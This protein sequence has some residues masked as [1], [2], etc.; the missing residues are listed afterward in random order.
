M[1]TRFATRAT[2]VDDTINV[3]ENLQKHFLCPRVVL[4]ATDGLHRQDTMLPPQCVLV[5]SRPK[6]LVV[7]IISLLTGSPQALR[8]VFWGKAARAEKLGRV[9][10]APLALLPTPHSRASFWFAPVPRARCYQNQAESLSGRLQSRD[11]YTTR[12]FRSQRSFNRVTFTCCFCSQHLVP[13]PVAITH[14]W[15]AT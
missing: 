3:S 12:V 14:A 8:F 10:K 11:R 2:F 15:L 4:F 5:L 7:S 1:L 6:Y 9:I 13:L